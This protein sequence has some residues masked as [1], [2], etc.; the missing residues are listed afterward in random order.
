MSGSKAAFVATYDETTGDTTVALR[1]RFAPFDITATCSAAACVDLEETEAP[2]DSDGGYTTT[3][4]T[5]LT[6][7][8][9]VSRKDNSSN[10]THAIGIATTRLGAP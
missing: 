8:S 7:V 2:I 1:M 10:V 9:Q 5:I 3:N 6:N 4:V